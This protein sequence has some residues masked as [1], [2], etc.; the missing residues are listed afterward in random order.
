MVFDYQSV[1][2][3]TVAAFR[4]APGGNGGWSRHWL[5]K[6]GDPRSGEDRR[7]LLRPHPGASQSNMD[8]KARL[9]SS[10]LGVPGSLVSR[11]RLPPATPRSLPNTDRPP[12]TQRRLRR[13]AVQGTKT[14][15]SRVVLHGNRT[16]RIARL[17]LVVLRLGKLGS[18]PRLLFLTKLLLGSTRRIIR[19]ILFMMR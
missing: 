15:D 8:V 6:R 9:A 14:S 13:D 2:K 19:R 1:T 7:N 10:C 17:D 3:S 12:D 5:P 16:Q 18:L 4:H 11:N